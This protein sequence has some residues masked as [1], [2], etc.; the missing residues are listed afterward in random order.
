MLTLLIVSTAPAAAAS[1]P[2]TTT[3]QAGR[4]ADASTSECTPIGDGWLSCTETYVSV[5]SGTQS[6]S[7]G[8]RERVEVACVGI[9]THQVNPESGEGVDGVME[10]GCS[11]VSPGALT[12]GRKLSGV[13]LLPTTVALHQYTCDHSGCVPTTSRNVVLTGSWTGDGPV[14]SG[15]GRNVFEGDGCRYDERGKAQAREATFAGMV[16]GEAMEAPGSIHQ[17]RFTFR[18]R[19][20]AA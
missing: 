6:M 3:T 16:A 17:G 8:P 2:W 10:D 20:A 18:S 19:C 5:F 13:E 4:S 1:N 9:Y 11:P 15:R 7:G 14:Y 12:F